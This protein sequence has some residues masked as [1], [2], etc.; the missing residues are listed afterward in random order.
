[1]YPIQSWGLINH[2][3]HGIGQIGVLMKKVSDEQYQAG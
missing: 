3:E 2:G 1:M